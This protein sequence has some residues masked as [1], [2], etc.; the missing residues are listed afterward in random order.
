MVTVFPIRSASKSFKED[1]TGRELTLLEAVIQKQVQIL[2]LQ[3]IRIYCKLYSVSVAI[4]PSYVYIFCNLILFANCTSII[5]KLCKN[6]YC[7]I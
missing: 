1:K 2:G 5:S 7:G 4:I 6:V 3:R